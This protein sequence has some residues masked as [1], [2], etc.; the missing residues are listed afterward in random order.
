VTDGALALATLA[1]ALAL[2]VTAE[3]AREP[4][5]ALA[6]ALVVAYAVLASIRYDTG[7]GYVVPTQVLLV[8]MLLLLPTP[9]VPALVGLALML[10]AAV[11]SARGGV[12]PERIVVALADAWIALPPAA[13]L[14][15]AGAQLPDWGDWPIY[16]AAVAAQFGADVLVSVARFRAAVGARPREVLHEVVAA[17][18]IDAV[19]FPVGLLVA[20]GAAT[21][22]WTVL[23]VLPLAAL[24]ALFGREHEERVARSLEL[25]Q[26]YRG[27][28]LLLGDVIGED[29]AY[30]GRHTGG[31]VELALAIAD[32]LHVDTQT[33]QVTELGALLHDVGKI[34]IAKEILHKPAPLDEAEWAVMRTHTIVGQRMLERV[35]GLLAEVGMVVRASHEHWDGGGYPDGLAGEQIPLPAR[36]VAVSDAYNA[37]VTDRPYRRA[38]TT[39]WAVAEL[40]THAGTQFDPAVVEACVAVVGD[41]S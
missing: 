23:L 13:V 26:A 11:Q 1:A 36:V 12:A 28:A 4:D 22:P 20:M 27:T 24:F 39:S 14:V 41:A 5:P 7:A 30:T 10:K 32:A 33:R 17:A 37:I 31:V 35:G 19:L 29:D 8:P 6:S 40:R 2:A 34:A 25:Y 18:R 38:Q 21:E 16:V 15:A 9:L 3:P